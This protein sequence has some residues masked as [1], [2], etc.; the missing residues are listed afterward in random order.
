MPHPPVLVPQVGMGRELDAEETLRGVRRLCMFLPDFKDEISL[1]MSPHFTYFPGRLT[2]GGSDIY[3]GNLASF[4]APEVC[5]QYQGDPHFIRELFQPIDGIIP[6][7]IDTTTKELDHGTFVPLVLL[8]GGGKRPSKVIPLNPVG[9]TRFQAHDLGKRLRDGI[10][11]AGG[12]VGI[13][14]SGDLSHRLSPHGPYGFSPWG[15]VFDDMVIEA[16]S[17]GDPSDLLK[18]E[19]EQ[20]QEAGQ[21]GLNIVLA[22]IGLTQQPLRVLSYEGP[23]GV[24]YAVAVMRPRCIHP[25][26]DFARLVLMDLLDN[27]QPDISSI[28]RAAGGDGNLWEARGG[29]FVSLYTS[30]GHL[31]GCMGTIEPTSPSISMEIARNAAAAAFEDPR[32]MPVILDELPRLKISVDVLSPLEDASTEDLNPKV[33]GVVVSTGRR[34]G[35]L[36]PD[37][38]G[39]NTVRDQLDIARMKA[40]IGGHE[41]IKIQRFTVHRYKEP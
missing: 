11:A 29:C 4:S 5:S 1:V 26:V 39:V 23:F 30:D 13:L 18:L 21:C 27:R 37:L 24:G 20:V 25:Y 28:I 32:F 35:V 17:Q 6:M 34:R 38:N 16:L 15:R 31:R 33:Y 3:N 12:H 22:F 10:E 36:L 41:E 14:F 8:Q 9:L 40:G 19:E 7:M 2:I